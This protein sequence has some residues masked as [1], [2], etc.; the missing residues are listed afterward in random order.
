LR[1]LHLDAVF[2]GVHGISETAGF[3]TPNLLEAE[4]NRAFVAATDHL[5]VLADHTKWNV[6]G[7]VSIAPLEAAAELITDRGLPAGARATLQQ[8]IASVVLADP[9]FADLAS[10]TEIPTLH[11]AAHRTRKRA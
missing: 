2:M 5:V 4:T 6:T 10:A 11:D 1:S 9:Q 7:L 3:T 8:H